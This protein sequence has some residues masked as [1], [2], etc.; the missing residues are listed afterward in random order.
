[1]NFIIGRN[2][3]ALT[4]FVPFDCNNNCKFCTSKSGYRTNPPDIYQVK[5]SMKEFFENCDFPITDVVFTGGEPMTNISLL[6]E[7][8]DLVP[9]DKNVFINTTLPVKNIYDFILLVNT[10]P[11][12]KGISISRHCESY[13]ED[14]QMFHN[15]C[16][17]DV[18]RMFTKPVRINCV[19]SN[20]DIN[21]LICRWKPFNVT[22]SLRKDFTTVHSAYDLHNP[23]DT[24]TELLAKEGK[25]INHTQCN[26]CDTVRFSMHGFIVQYHRGLEHTAIINNR[27]VEI[28]DLIIFQNG[29][30][31][32]DW[33][34]CTDSILDS[35]LL[36]Y[37]K[38]KNICNLNY[39]YRIPGPA[40]CG[41][42]NY[43]ESYSSIGCGGGSCGGNYRESHYSFRC[44][45]GGGCG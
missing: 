18:V 36:V 27:T 9:E 16:R 41:G 8:I 24:I 19:I 2:N 40:S 22:L 39:T 13:E 15:I 35:L 30:F 10:E 11:K 43:R 17:D 4:V 26:V 28:N 14:C 7:L 37:K 45:G 5:L 44:G 25:W 33:E 31:A 23:Y 38:S 34:G 32:Y 3:L 20:Q 12:I 21:K 1:M 42:G 6:K 29:D